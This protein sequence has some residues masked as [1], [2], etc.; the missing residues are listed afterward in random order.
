MGEK[1][2]KIS[3]REFIRVSALAVAG[4]AAAACAKTPEP[5]KS[6]TA[7]PKVSERVVREEEATATFVPV[8]KKN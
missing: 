4:V 5:P 3:R 8:K 6:P 7:E 1:L 2:E